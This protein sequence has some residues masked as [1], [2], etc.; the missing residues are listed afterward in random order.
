MGAVLI[1]ELLAKISSEYNER[2]SIKYKNKPFFS[3]LD[4]F[5]GNK[6]PK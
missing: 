3:F 6:E 4:P 5:G 1:T 2:F